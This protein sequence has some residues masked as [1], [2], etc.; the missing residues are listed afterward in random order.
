LSYGSLS[1]ANVTY[2]AE[3]SSTPPGGSTFNGTYTGTFSGTETSNGKTIA[4]GVTAVIDNGVFTV[5]SPGN[6]TGTVNSTGQIVFGVDVTEGVSC[7][8]SGQDVVTGTAAVASG[9]F[10]CES[11]AISGNW[12]VT[13]E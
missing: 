2:Q 7:S 8:F 11:G 4:G 5:T 10:T 1:V 6:G 13:R 9:T 12:T 3:A